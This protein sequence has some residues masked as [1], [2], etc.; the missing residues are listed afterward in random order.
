[1]IFLIK[2]LSYLGPALVIGWLSMV[3]ADWYY[4]EPFYLSYLILSLITMLT[5]FFAATRLV[6]LDLIFPLQ[7]GTF[8]RILVVWTGTV[9]VSWF[10]NHLLLSGFLANMGNTPRLSVFLLLFSWF[11]GLALILVWTYGLSLLH[12]IFSSARLKL[13]QI[14]VLTLLSVLLVAVIG[15]IFLSIHIQRRFQNRIFTVE[16]VP[17][18][19]TAIV[20]GAGVYPESGRPS[21]VLRDRLQTAA[22]LVSA[23]KV[24]QVL[25][26]GDGTPGSIEVDVMFQYAL[27]I[28]IPEEM[29]LVDREGFRSYKTC[30]NAYNV[31]GIR[32]GLLVTQNFH[33]P[34][35]LCLCESM[36]M[37]VVGVRADLSKYS[38]LGQVNW[39]LRESVA[40]AYAWLEVMTGR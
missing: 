7:K 10:I 14:G 39:A 15:I 17:M 11:S 29:L 20:F 25:L 16:S 37:Q 9:L 6:Q 4:R 5:L 23:G 38:P 2:I 1:M 27:D 33:L 40:R 24:D 18:T 36:G 32:K 8:L 26:S 22:A 30:F 3:Q 31:F 34:R 28:G 35:A 12:L 13:L 19:G 21:L